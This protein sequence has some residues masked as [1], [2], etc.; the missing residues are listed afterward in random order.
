MIETKALGAYFSVIG[1]LSVVEPEVMRRRRCSM[2]PSRST[3]THASAFVNGDAKRIVAVSPTEYRD[4]SGTTS[5]LN[6]VSSFH[7]TQPLPDAQRTKL[8]V[9]RRPPRSFALNVIVYV[10][11]NFGVIVQGTGSGPVVTVHVMTVS[12][13]QSP[14]NSTIPARSR[15]TRCHS[16]RTTVP[17]TRTL[18]SRSP[19]GRTAMTSTVC[20]EPAFQK[21]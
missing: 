17:V 3:V 7:G 19:S 12:D 9:A 16:R 1:N 15:R 20:V 14:T 6:C 18:D 11:P 10:P 5:I 2:R 13:T 8:V 21:Y 4:L